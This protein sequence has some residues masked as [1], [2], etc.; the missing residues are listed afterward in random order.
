VTS[1]TAIHAEALS[2]RY[3][4]GQGRGYQL[5]S[6]KI[7]DA[8]RAFRRRIGRRES[9]AED[10]LWALDSVS[11]SV[12]AGEVVGII[13]RNG[14]GKTTLLK[15]LSRITAPTRGEFRLYGRVGTLLE[16]GTGFHGELTGRENVYFS[17]AVLGMKRA[18]IARKFD[19]IVAFAEIDRF[20]DTPVKRYSTGMY[21]RLAFSVAAH[22]EPEILLVDEVLA[23]G[24][25]RFQRKCLNRM[26]E[27]AREGR[28]VLFV[29]HSMTS[30]L[31]ICKRVILLERGVVGADGPAH[32]VVARY[33]TSDSGSAGERVWADGSMG[34][35]DAI[36]RMRAVRV[37]DG[38]GAVVE[39][40]DVGESVLVEIEYV[41]LQG[42]GW[43]V[44][45]VQFFNAEGVCMFAGAGFSEQLDGGRSAESSL[46]RARCKIP[47][48]LLSE[49]RVFVSA[50][51]VTY[52][53]LTT[54]H[55][56][57][58]DAVSFQVVDRLGA[59]PLRQHYAG[60]WPGVVRPKLDWDICAE[61]LFPLG[62]RG[63]PLDIE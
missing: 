16:V 34:P 22:L 51:V 14:A 44:A 21:M 40:V 37:L 31:R 46:V 39:T 32:E 30:V 50:A 28:T 10:T 2:K 24:D 12:E 62:N 41:R 4:I 18:E 60:E 35:G 23:V 56:A 57:E 9:V 13:G 25:A 15:V 38:A 8:L 6:E 5:L 11:F 20:L 42:P 48:H 52:G 54:V 49:G 29:S 27:V 47:A 59:D 55:A 36:A 58:R 63:R 61:P 7:V 19:A 43:P 3:T 17:G 45:A 26:G 1:R 53:Y 33:M